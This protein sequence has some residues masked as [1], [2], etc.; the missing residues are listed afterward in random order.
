MPVPY[1]C[2]VAVFWK[3]NPCL[4]SQGY[5]WRGISLRGGHTP[6]VTCMPGYRDTEMSFLGAGAVH[7]LKD[8]GCAGRGLCT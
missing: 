7:S 4:V 8:V 6:S 2:P 3:Q 1:A 5:S